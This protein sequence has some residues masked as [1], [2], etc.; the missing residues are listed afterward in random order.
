MHQIL[1][2][3]AQ[4]CQTICYSDLATQIQTAYIHHRAPAF[5]SILH[6][7]VEEDTA[8]GYPN[9]AVLVVRKQTGRCGTGFFRDAAANGY[10]GSDQEAFWVDSFDRVCDYWSE[11]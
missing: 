5:M 10:D 1:I 7:L 6:D 2:G 4:R 11:M 3:L 8:A 9:L